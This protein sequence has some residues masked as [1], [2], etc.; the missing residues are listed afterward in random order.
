MTTIRV[1]AWAV[2]ISDGCLSFEPFGDKL[3]WFTFEAKNIAEVEKA[4]EAQLE[5]TH[6]ARLELAKAAA[7]KYPENGFVDFSIM[8]YGGRKFANFDKLAKPLERKLRLNASEYIAAQQ[9][10]VADA[11]SFLEEIGG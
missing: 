10:L 2:C 8:V 3:A 7:R 4:I 1:T 5:K 9:E 6:K 11:V